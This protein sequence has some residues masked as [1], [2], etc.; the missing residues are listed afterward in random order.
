MTRDRALALII[1]PLTL[2]PLVIWVIL[3]GRPALIEETSPLPNGLVAGM[4]IAPIITVGLMIYYLAHLYRK[5]GLD[6]HA[7]VI[8]LL[9]IVFLNV[10]AMPF[11]WYFYVWRERPAGAA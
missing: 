1:L 11:Y 7:R 5:S 9:A 8:W 4:L 3:L 10:I 2:A 6:I